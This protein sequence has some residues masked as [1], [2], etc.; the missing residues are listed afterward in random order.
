MTNESIS[1]LFVK[2]RESASSTMAD[3]DHGIIK[4]PIR[5]IQTLVIGS[6]FSGYRPTPE[7]LERIENY[8]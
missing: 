3:L 7:M 1:E 4:K 6:F 8:D 2:A 5:L